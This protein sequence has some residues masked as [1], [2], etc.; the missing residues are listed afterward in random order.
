MGDFNQPLTLHIA[1]TRRPLQLHSVERRPAGTTSRQGAG[2]AL[3]LR[4]HGWSG[5][6]LLDAVAGAQLLTIQP[7]KNAQTK[8][9]AQEA[10]R[11]CAIDV[12][13]EC[14]GRAWPVSSCPHQRT[15]RAVCGRKPALPLASWP[16]SGP[17]A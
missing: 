1:G 5:F 9:D 14:C 17:W 12:L 10:W 6:W 8:S 15:P 2:P 4:T 3:H 11:A 13:F 7:V 16:A